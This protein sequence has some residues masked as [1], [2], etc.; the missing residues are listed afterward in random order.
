MREMGRQSCSQS[1]CFH[2][3]GRRSSVECFVVKAGSP[4][5]RRVGIFQAKDGSNRFQLETGQGFVFVGDNVQVSK[6]FMLTHVEWLAENFTRGVRELVHSSSTA[7]CEIFRLSF[8]SVL[9]DP[10]TSSV[11]FRAM[12]AD[13]LPTMT[14]NIPGTTTQCISL[15]NNCKSSGPSARVIVF[16]SPG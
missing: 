11:P 3:Q 8:H 1:C 14:S 16:F 6:N 15:S 13:D 2:R 10:F 4:E 7:L 9:A 12:S 5:T